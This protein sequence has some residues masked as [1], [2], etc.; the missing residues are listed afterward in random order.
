MAPDVFFNIFTHPWHYH[1]ASKKKL[2]FSINATWKENNGNDKRCKTWL[3]N[4]GDCGR[5][6]LSMKR[7]EEQRETSWIKRVA[8]KTLSNFKDES[9]RNAYEQ[10]L[11]EYNAR[12]SVGEAAKR[13]SK[14]RLTKLEKL[15]FLLRRAPLLRNG[16]ETFRQYRK[17]SG[18]HFFRV[19]LQSF[20]RTICARRLKVTVS[21]W[22]VKRRTKTTAA[23]FKS[24]YVMQKRP[25]WGGLTL[26]IFHSDSSI[27]LKNFKMN[28]RLSNTRRRLLPV[29]QSWSGKDLQT[30]QGSNWKG[31]P[32]KNGM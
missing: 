32:S 3:H 17:T 1:Q 30:Q 4:I 19:S 8:I 25:N 26:E 23:T 20:C 13:I 5:N 6:F 7:Q 10:V 9:M 28:T 16:S 12:K 24:R 22:S 31:T 18:R 27:S 21:L 2:S 29:T 11:N 14:E 15:G